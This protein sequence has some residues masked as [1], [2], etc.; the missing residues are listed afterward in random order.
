MAA[1]NDANQTTWYLIQ[2]NGKPVGYEQ[3][4]TSNV[5]GN[6]NLLKVFRRTEL[7]IRRLG[8]DV[9]L[10]TFL[11]TTQTKNGELL[12]FDL[13]QIDAAGKRIERSGAQNPNK[14]TFEIQE[15]IAATKSQRSV[16]IQPSPM[17]PIVELC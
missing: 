9:H 13:Q 6:P 2:M 12:A 16:K 14:R 10:Q 4:T 8:S 11:W 1:T 17:S 7:R 3:L 5:N 15:R